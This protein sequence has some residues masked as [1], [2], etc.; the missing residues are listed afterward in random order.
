MSSYFAQNGKVFTPKYKDGRTKQSFKDQCDINKMLKKA[1]T[2][3]SIAHLQKYPEAVYGEFEGIDLLTAH[4]RIVRANEIFADAPSEVRKEF[5]NNALKFAAWASNPENNSKLRELLPK[6][7]EPGTY[8][9]NPVKRGG[10]GAGVAT[11]APDVA[12]E[13]PSEPAPADAA[14]SGS[15]QETPGD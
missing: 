13:T 1:Q 4:N 12:P 2:Q 10:T 3:G 15:A 6:L 5:D 8:F 14:P 9:P 7:A 11:P